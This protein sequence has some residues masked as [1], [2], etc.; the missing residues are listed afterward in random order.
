VL[1]NG[2]YDALWWAGVDT[3]GITAVNYIRSEQRKATG[4][5]APERQN[6]GNVFIPP[7]VNISFS[8]PGRGVGE[9]KGKYTLAINPARDRIL[10]WDGSLLKELSL[11]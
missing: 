11:P 8:G 4:S 1:R 5:L 7:F 10:Y 9:Q 6:D 2:F 3:S